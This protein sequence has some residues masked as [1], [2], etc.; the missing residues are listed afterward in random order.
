MIHICK[1][2]FGKLRILSGL[3]PMVLRL[4]NDVDESRTWKEFST[5]CMIYYLLLTEFEVRIVSYGLSFFPLGLMSQARSAR[6]INP[7]G[8]NEDP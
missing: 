8:K 7:S 4:T 3:V 1:V 6:A 2:I 5:K